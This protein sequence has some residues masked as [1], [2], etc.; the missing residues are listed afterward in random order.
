MLRR[1][2]IQLQTFLVS[3]LRHRHV[4]VPGRN[5]RLAWLKNTAGLPF[6][7]AD[8]RMACQPFS[9]KSR[10]DWRHVLHDND[11]YGK[12]PWYVWN[13]LSQRVGPAR[14][15]SDRYDLNPAACYTGPSHGTKSR[16]NIRL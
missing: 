4:E 15:C 8:L 13:H 7:D 6:L 10:K 16:R 1:V 14:R 11:G 3:G 5:P 12:I 2:L 9:Q